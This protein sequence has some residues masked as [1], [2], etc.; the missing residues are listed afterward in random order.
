MKRGR[1]GEGCGGC[2]CY[3]VMT[4]S[5]IA[6]GRD[7]L[8]SIWLRWRISHVTRNSFFFFFGVHED[9]FSTSL[10]HVPLDI[11]TRGDMN[12]VN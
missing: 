1:E 7:P 10:T 6:F 9:K 4:I 3:R 12:L 2:E 5:C 11:I 8:G